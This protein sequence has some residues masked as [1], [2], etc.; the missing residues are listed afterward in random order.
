MTII[1]LP[2]SKW[3]EGKS[4]PISWG[5]WEVACHTNGMPYPQD[6]GKIF[7]TEVAK[8]CEYFDATMNEIMPDMTPKHMV[9]EGALDRIC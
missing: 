2:Q 1:K 6:V 3:E 5:G 8:A 7:E 4:N 9:S